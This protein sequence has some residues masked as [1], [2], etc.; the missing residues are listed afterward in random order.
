MG[1]LTE[2]HASRIP[3]RDDL[4]AAIERA[5]T[6]MSR[7]GTW[8][9]GA[10]RV[11]IAAEARA[12]R[13]CSMCRDR[14]AALSPQAVEGEHEHLG[15]LEAVAVELIHRIVTDPARQT[16]SSYRATLALGISDAEYVEIVGTVATVVGIDAFHRAAGFP[17]KDLPEP[18]PGEASLRRPSRARLEGAWVPM[19]A[20]DALDPEDADLY[21]K[22]RNGNVIRA[23]SLVTD[24]VRG[25]IDQSQNFYIE[26]LADHT[27]GRSITRPQIELIA[28]RVSALNEC[29]Y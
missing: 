14:K 5:W 9:T 24:E 2:D 1:E 23:L 12:A 16:E 18:Q 28:A 13:S 20:P 27:A 8:W 25:L 17:L 7:P 21:T 4:T 26:D 29:Y 3:I 6:R 10:Q 11:T 22:D 15:R 19:V